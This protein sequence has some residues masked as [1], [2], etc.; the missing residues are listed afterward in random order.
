M[1]PVRAIIT[2]LVLAGIGGQAAAADVFY[3][4]SKNSTGKLRASS[5]LAN[6]VPTCKPT[7]MLRTWAETGPQG[8]TGPSDAFHTFADETPLPSGGTFLSLAEL[9]LPAGSYVVTAKTSLNNSNAAITAIAYCAIILGTGPFGL[10]DQT[11]ATID[12]VGVTALSAVLPI[13]FSTPQ[14]VQFRCTNNTPSSPG[15]VMAQHTTMVAIRVGSLTPPQG[16]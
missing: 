3:S 8:P 7:E 11:L 16:P 14:T 13:S 2:V 15:D 6:T 4:C 9:A 12:G 10:N 1:I 5:V